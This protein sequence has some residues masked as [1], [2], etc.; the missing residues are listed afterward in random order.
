MES[1]YYNVWKT[2]HFFP[3]PLTFFFLKN[4]N[5]FFPSDAVPCM[6]QARCYHIECIHLTNVKNFVFDTLQLYW[7]LQPISYRRQGI[8]MQLILF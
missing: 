1:L 8:E 2:S 7:D 5:K 4:V 3:P 6:F